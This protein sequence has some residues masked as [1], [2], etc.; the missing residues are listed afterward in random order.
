M[1]RPIGAYPDGAILVYQGV[2]FGLLGPIRDNTRCFAALFGPI[3]GPT[4][5]GVGVILDLFG[6]INEDYQ[7]RAYFLDLLFMYSTIK[8]IMLP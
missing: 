7:L 3:F 6:S 5:E 1:C 2:H 8:A 4:Q